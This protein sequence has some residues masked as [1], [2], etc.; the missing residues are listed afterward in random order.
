MD[1]GVGRWRRRHACSVRQE[2]GKPATR[3]GLP[4]LR[5]GHTQVG[6]AGVGN[7]ELA[8]ARPRR[9]R[10]LGVLVPWVAG[11]KAHLRGAKVGLFGDPYGTRTRV[12]G[13]KGRSPRPLDER[14][15]W[16]AG[17]LAAIWEKARGFL[18]ILGCGE[19][20]GGEGKGRLMGAGGCYRFWS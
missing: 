16:G 14:V 13:V 8:G 12:A 5:L 2:P 3:T 17:T 19:G 20:Q 10:T 15:A 4:R 1:R 18:G 9:I 7:R 11:K 6:F